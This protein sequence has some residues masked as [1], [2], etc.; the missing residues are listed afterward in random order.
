MTTVTK[1]TRDNNFAIFWND[2]I[3]QAVFRAT[4]RWYVLKSATDKSSILVTTDSPITVQPNVSN[5]TTNPQFQPQQLMFTI[6]NLVEVDNGV[7]AAYRPTAIDCA[8]GSQWIETYNT[9]FDEVVQQLISLIFNGCCS[10]TVIISG[11]T[12]SWVDTYT[13]LPITGIEGVLYI[14]EDTGFAYRWE[15]AASESDYVFVSKDVLSFNSY[16]A[17]PVIG[18]EDIIY[19]DK[20]TNK[21]YRWEG[22]A[23]ES[24]YVELVQ[25]VVPPDGNYGGVVVSGS[26]LVW[27]LAAGGNNTEVLYNQAGAI[28]GAAKLL[29]D[30]DEFPIV[31]PKQLTSGAS[32]GTA[33]A[34]GTRFQDFRIAGRDSMGQVPSVGRWHEFQHALGTFKGMWWVPLG[35]STSLTVIG[36]S[37]IATGTATA[38]TVAVTTFLTMMRRIGVASAA[39]AGSSAGY[40][41]GSLQYALSASGAGGFALIWRFGLPTGTA[42]V[43]GMRWFVGFT[44]SAAAIGNVDP[45]SLTNIIGFGIDSTIDTNIQV[46]HNDAAGA[47]TKVDLGASFPATTAN[48]VYEVRLVNQIG[49]SNVGYSVERLDTAAFIEGAIST[50]LPATTVL[51]APQAL[52]NNGATAV[53]IDIDLADLFLDTTF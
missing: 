27:T 38:R 19:I 37:L 1:I 32:P 40:R 2:T 23:S 11:G 17:F 30:A 34:S 46:M 43:A 25:S 53:A 35:N 8:P 6:E 33:P 31:L 41:S 14:V 15:G 21:L 18:D 39:G 9:Q 52:I 51:M 24:D 12:I 5:R 28:G 26:G 49:S 10:D 36:G 4:D 50:N 29:I 48:A 13:D 22:A 3:I 7:D 20:A 44:A 45:S 47:A 16:A 42:T